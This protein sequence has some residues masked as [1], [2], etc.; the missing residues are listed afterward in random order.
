MKIGGRDTT[1]LPLVSEYVH[2]VMLGI[3]WFEKNGVVCDFARG[4]L[5]PA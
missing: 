5:P 1:I 3:E 2:E 4:K